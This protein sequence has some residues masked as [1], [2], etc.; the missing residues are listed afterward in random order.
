[1][2]NETNETNEERILRI[3]RE[4]LSKMTPEELQM[5]LDETDGPSEPDTPSIVSFDYT[6]KGTN[7]IRL[8]MDSLKKHGITWDD[9]VQVI[10]VKKQ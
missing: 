2:C 5:K 3:F 10:L 1:M 6:I 7:T 8:D 9:T 4:K